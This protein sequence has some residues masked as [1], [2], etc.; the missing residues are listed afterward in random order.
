VSL[1]PEGALLLAGDRVRVE[2][3]V[4]PGAWL[5]MVEPAGTVAYSS[6][7]PGDG[8]DWEVDVELGPGASLRWAGRPF[9]VAQGAEVRR[10]TRVRLGAGSSLV[11]REVLVLGRTGEGPGTLHSGLR[12]DGPK[13]PL[14]AEDLDLG[15]SA[16][17][18]MLGGA[19]V[20][21]S[22]L[23]VGWPPPE[24][25]TDRRLDLDGGGHLWRALGAEV[26]GSGLDAVVSAL[27]QRTG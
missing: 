5:E 24:V 14:L 26:H 4:G 6:S 22:L 13:H 27:P 25:A 3:V 10:S 20:L 19:R 1:V 2:V 7:T 15:P 16:P 12:V 8:A 11:L 18:V 23:V 21:D 9:V 17:P